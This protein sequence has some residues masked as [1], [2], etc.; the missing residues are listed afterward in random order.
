MYFKYL[1]NKIYTHG[2]VHAAPRKNG[3]NGQPVSRK[4]NL[5]QVL[6]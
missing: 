4:Y 1:K 6:D 2:S 3:L 5:L